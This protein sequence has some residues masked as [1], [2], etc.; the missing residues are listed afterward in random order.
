M[1]NTTFRD[2]SAFDDTSSY[3]SRHI[4]FDLGT[5]F[6]N[7]HDIRSPGK[8]NIP[9]MNLDEY[10]FNNLTPTNANHSDFNDSKI[11]DQMV[12]RNSGDN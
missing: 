9:S 10:Q 6:K 8:L 2:R 12:I 7:K 3:A 1:D 11:I 4:G 5:A